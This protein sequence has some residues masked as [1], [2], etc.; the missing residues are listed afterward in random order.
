MAKA[1]TKAKANGN[2]KSH[3]TQQSVNQTV[4]SICDILRRSNCKGAMQYVP[5]LTWILFLRI[6]DEREQKEAEEAQMFGRSFAPSLAEPY[7]WHDWAA[8]PEESLITQRDGKPQGWKRRELEE[9]K[10][11]GFIAWVN[12]ELLPYLHDLEKQPNAAPRQKVI[13]E[14]MSGVKQVRVDTDKNFLDVLDKVHLISEQNID[15]THLFPL[16]QVFEGLL[17][18]MGEKGNDGGQF[19]T[20]REVIRA[21]VKVVDPKIGETVYDAACGT[22]GF[23]AQAYEYMIGE[24]GEKA[25]AGSDFDILKYQTF[26]DANKTT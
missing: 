18:K 1:V 19:F 2:G 14:V 20:P 13:S 17:L 21:M 22:G 15:T 10:T 24:N 9:G 25:K 6:L 11:N 4:K 5:E 16:S 26:S 8:T 23:L 3:L 7:R 12:S